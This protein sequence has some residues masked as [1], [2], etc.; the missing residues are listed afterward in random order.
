[1]TTGTGEV[2]SVPS[3]RPSSATADDGTTTALDA[4]SSA[5]TRV[6]ERLLPSVVSVRVESAGP[7][8]EARKGGGSAIIITPDGFLLTS[9]HVVHGVRRAAV[10][11][12]TGEQARA[13]IVGADRHSDL[14]VIRC[15]ASGL[16]PAALGDAGTL[17]V[18]QLVVA[19]GSPLG[20]SGSLSAGVVSGLGRSLPTGLGLG[21]RI[22][23][24]V[25]QTDAALHPGN[26]GGAL[27]TTNAEVVGVNTAVVGPGIGQGLGLAVPINAF[28]RQ[29]IGSIMSTGRV[30]R[31]YLGIGGV[32]QPLPASAARTTGQDRAI[33]VAMISCGSPAQVGGLRV[34]DRILSLDGVRI[35]DLATLQSL[36]DEARIG[37]SVAVEVFREDAQWT[38]VVALG[39]LAD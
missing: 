5:V 38:V 10:E 19:V 31:A 15:D 35:S 7:R 29:I 32:S 22:V 20:Y 1:M 21:S 23:D 16:V 8:G 34:G 37:R 25:I 18:G 12:A 36:M 11:F 13:E 9:A 27:A 30:R 4:Y 17:R 33:T 14:A 39:E 26:S 2:M 28:T 24:N 6:A 3:S